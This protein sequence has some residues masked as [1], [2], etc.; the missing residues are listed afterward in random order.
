MAIDFEAEG[1]L[2]GTRGRY[3]Q[4]RLQLLGELAA[5]GVGLEELRRAVA[6]ANGSWTLFASQSRNPASVSGLGSVTL[7]TEVAATGAAL[8]GLA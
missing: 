8:G 1:L 5:D 4:A 2:K 3:R 7:A 6:E